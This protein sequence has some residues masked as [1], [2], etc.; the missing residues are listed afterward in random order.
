MTFEVPKLHVASYGKGAEE[1]GV[2][3][4]EGGRQWLFLSRSVLWEGTGYEH[5]SGEDGDS[6]DL[7]TA[8]EKRYMISMDRKWSFVVIQ[9]WN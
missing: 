9:C 4:G 5:Y 8:S 1:P 2:E 7:V 3:N 6:R